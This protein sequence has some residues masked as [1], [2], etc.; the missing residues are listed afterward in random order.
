MPTRLW[1]EHHELNTIILSECKSGCQFKWKSPPEVRISNINVREQCVIIANSPLL[2]FLIY[3]FKLI[4]AVS[5]IIKSTINMLISYSSK[6]YFR[7]CKD[8][9]NLEKKN[10]KIN[11]R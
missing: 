5:S 10:T 8:Q 9:G 11:G 7:R 4:S 6:K 2:T 1:F 3:L